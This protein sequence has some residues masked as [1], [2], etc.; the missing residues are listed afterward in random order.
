MA[1]LTSKKRWFGARSP[2]G[3]ER[4]ENEKVYR[5][6]GVLKRKPT[7]LLLVFEHFNLWE[8]RD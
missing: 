1:V 5:K 4:F 2:G 8:K 3:E 7:L 6:E